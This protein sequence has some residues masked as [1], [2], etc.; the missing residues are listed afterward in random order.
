MHFSAQQGRDNIMMLGPERKTML[1]LTRGLLEEV[2]V[3][4]STSP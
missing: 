1:P 3:E 4:P 2:G